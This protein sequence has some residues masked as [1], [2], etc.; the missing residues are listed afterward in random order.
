MSE[1][2]DISFVLD[3]NECF[4]EKLCDQ[5]ARCT[6]TDGSYKCTCESG[7]IENGLTC[8]GYFFKKIP[9]LKL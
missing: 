5:K 4:D 3:I 8:T 6:N 2:S 1:I 9:L 7:Y